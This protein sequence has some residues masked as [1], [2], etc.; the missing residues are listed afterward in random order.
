[1]NYF[2]ELPSRIKSGSTFASDWLD[3]ILKWQKFSS[4]ATL[5]PVIVFGGQGDYA[6]QG[7]R[8]VGWRELRAIAL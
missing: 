5:P 4:D 3:A 2:C 7:C 8:G 6:R 1:M